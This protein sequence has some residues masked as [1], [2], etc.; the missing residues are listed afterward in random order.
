MST[1]RKPRPA[2]AAA[3]V[4]DPA[5]RGGAPIIEGTSTRVMD[6]AVRYELLG[7]TP[8]EIGC[9]LPH[10]D[11]ARIHAALSYYYAHKEALDAEWKAAERRAARARTRSPSLLGRARA[12]AAALSR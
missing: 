9:A 6:V 10:L 5:R 7:M 12:A 11:L 2:P 4:R 3:I 1:V 8:D